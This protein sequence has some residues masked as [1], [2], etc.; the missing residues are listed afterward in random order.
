MLTRDQQKLLGA[1]G[2]GMAA[3][4]LLDEMRERTTLEGG[5][6]APQPNCWISYNRKAIWL[7][8]HSG[9]GEAMKAAGTDKQAWRR[10]KP[11]ILVKAT[12]AEAAAHGAGLPSALRDEL[13]SL[14]RTQRAE[15]R[16]W[17]EFSTARGGWPWRRRFATDE[18]HQAAQTEWDQAYA[19]HLATLR[20]VWDKTKAAVARALSLISDDEPVDLLELLDQ[21][22]AA[23]SDRPTG[24][25]L[26]AAALQHAPVEAMPAGVESSAPRPNRA[27]GR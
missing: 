5:C 2:A 18:L 26:Q 12:W 8:D 7:D 19:E 16:S 21:Q 27:V 15:D 25:A 20:D 24:A 4:A 3:S 9:F 11:E 6:S 1:A 14:R 10:I 17:S 23:I 22:S 13:D